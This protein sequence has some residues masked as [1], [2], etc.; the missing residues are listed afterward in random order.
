M[1]TLEFLA[2]SITQ[3]INLNQIA[4]HFGIN[5]KYKWEDILI[6]KEPELKGIL[7]EAEE[8]TVYCFYFG[9][10]VGINCTKY[11]LSD[12]YNYLCQIDS[13]I[14]R[15][16]DHHKYSEF[17]RLQIKENSQVEVHNNYLVAPKNLD[18]YPKIIAI[19]LADQLPLIELKTA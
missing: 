6:L 13:G 14:D 12:I 7:K 18:F 11:D 19:V 9:C 3:E 16:P 2:V 8:K 4:L 10:L 1:Q 5:K 15:K 17:Y